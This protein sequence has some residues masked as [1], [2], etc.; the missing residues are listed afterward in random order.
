APDAEEA[1]KVSNMAKTAVEWTHDLCRTL[2]TPALESS[3]LAEALRELAANAENIFSIECTFDQTG[4]E[5]DI[6]L[7]AGMHLY[8]IAQEAISNAVRHGAAKHVQIALV[9]SPRAV[10]MQIADDGRGINET[11]KSLDGMGLQIMRYRARMIGATMDV[12]PQ[13]LEGTI[14][15]C[16]YVLPRVSERKESY[17][18]N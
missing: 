8:R 10:D 13:E 3:G 11:N 15:T 12:R 1:M 14:V 16:H 17:V 5:H 18:N 7:T 4:D 9:G 6:E 2:A